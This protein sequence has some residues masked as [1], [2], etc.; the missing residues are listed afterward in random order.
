MAPA[1]ALPLK[2]ELLQNKVIRILLFYSLNL[3]TRPTALIFD[4]NAFLEDIKNSTRLEEIVDRINT[5]V[6][7]GDSFILIRNYNS[8]A[9]V[10]EASI[11][12]TNNFLLLNEDERVN[13]PVQEF[14][15][16]LENKGCY[17]EPVMYQIDK[18]VL[19]SS[20]DGTIAAG[21]IPVQSFFIGK[22]FENKEINYID[23]QVKYGVRYLYDIKQIRVVF[24]NKYMYK[25][26]KVF[27]SAIAGYGRALGNAL[28]FY[29]EPRQDVQLDDYVEEYVQE[30]ASKIVTHRNLRL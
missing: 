3:T 28:G 20:G 12:A 10:A 19:P 1:P 17:S 4:M 11:T 30:Y 15:K 27:F 24:G 23:S 7:T 29:R 13:Y 2:K 8:A 6:T 5:N 22:S 21:Q 18:Y 16:V 26:L 9:A 25:D 14:D